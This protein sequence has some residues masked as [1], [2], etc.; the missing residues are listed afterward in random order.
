MRR[1]AAAVLVGTLAVVFTGALI[2]LAARPASAHAGDELSHPIYE[3]MSP[4]VAGFDVQ[5]VFSANYELLVANHT[6]EPVTFLADSGEP[7]LRIGPAGVE[8]NFA[9]PT[10]YDSNSPE[11]LSSYPDRAKPGILA[12]LTLDRRFGERNQRLHLG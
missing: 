3:Q 8:A 10:F 5:V 9:S 12:M 7:F 6:P 1:L 2:E 11:G 4:L